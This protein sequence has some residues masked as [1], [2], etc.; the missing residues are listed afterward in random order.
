M[1]RLCVSI[2]IPLQCYS[3]AVMARALVG[4]EKLFLVTAP[5]QTI[6]AGEPVIAAAAGAITLRPSFPRSTVCLC[7]RF[8]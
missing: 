1:R 6:A 2:L 5:G 4:I 3:Q 8:R 7:L